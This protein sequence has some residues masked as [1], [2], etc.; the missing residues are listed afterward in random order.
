MIVKAGHLRHDSRLGVLTLDRQ[1]AADQLAVLCHAIER[2]GVTPRDVTAA[3][4]T[5]GTTSITILGPPG[6]DLDVVMTFDNQVTD[7]RPTTDDDGP[8]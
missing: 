4:L 2:A 7:P 1:L 3:E 6:A 8:R 5:E